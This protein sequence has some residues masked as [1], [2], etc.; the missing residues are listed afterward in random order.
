MRGFTPDHWLAPT[1]TG[2]RLP[3][4]RAHTAFSPRARAAS[5]SMPPGGAARSARNAWAGRRTGERFCP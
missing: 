3:R 5:K 1:V 2:A 4:P